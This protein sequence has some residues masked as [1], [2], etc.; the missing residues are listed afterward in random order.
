MIHS[1]GNS[2]PSKVPTM[3]VAELEHPDFDKFDVSHLRT[4]IMA[5]A[6]CPT[7]IMKRV[8]SKMHMSEI[9]IAYGMTETSPVSFQSSTSEPLEK[10]VKTVGRVHPHVEA[11]II[12]QSGRTVPPGTKGELLTRGYIVMQGYWN[13]E[14]RTRKAIDNAG[15][16]HTGDLAILDEEGYCSIVGRLTDMVI[17][18][19]ENIYPREIEEL[20]YSY[21][22]IKDVQVFGVPDSK[23]GEELCAWIILHED[24]TADEEEIHEFCKDKISHFKIP[25]YIRFK[26]EYP[27]TVTGKVQ[28]FMMRKEMVAELQ[29]TTT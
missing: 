7:E 3:F 21:H 16:M 11:K 9:T 27:M 26:D 1:S 8:I 2:V 24:E 23:F 17:R 6:P 22:K 18:G 10:R 14:E 12:D 4:G 29:N 20:L 5:G 28:K 19:G 13:D 15:W 25:R